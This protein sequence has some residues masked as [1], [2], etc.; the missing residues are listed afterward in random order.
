M[1]RQYWLAASFHP[2]SILNFSRE[3]SHTNFQRLAENNA[4]VY[5]L[6]NQSHKNIGRMLQRLHTQNINIK[7]NCHLQD[8]QHVRSRHRCQLYPINR[9]VGEIISPE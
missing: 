9:R 3:V 7:F 1:T 5:R 4:K 2:Y 6:F 8:A